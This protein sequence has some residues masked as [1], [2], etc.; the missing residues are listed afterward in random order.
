MARME[1][2]CSAARHDECVAVRAAGAAE[3]AVDG[4]RQ[5]GGRAAARQDGAGLPDWLRRVDACHGA[6]DDFVGCVQH[7]RIVTKAAC[8]AA[9]IGA[10]PAAMDRTSRS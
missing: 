6:A 7:T 5:L 8:S 4:R 10:S 9:R 1:D 3:E 2:T